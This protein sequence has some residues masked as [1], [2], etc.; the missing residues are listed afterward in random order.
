[1]TAIFFDPY[2]QKLDR[3]LSN[4]FKNEKKQQ[5]ELVNE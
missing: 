5:R 2:D 4:S 1:M 3:Y